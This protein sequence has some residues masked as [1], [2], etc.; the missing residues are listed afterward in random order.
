MNWD[1]EDYEPPTIDENVKAAWD[2]EDAEE[3]SKEEPAPQPAVA[4]VDTV[5]KKKKKELEAKIKEKEE[6]EAALLEAKKKEQEELDKLQ[7]VEKKLRMQKMVEESDFQNAR[8]IFMDGAAGNDQLGEES[9]DAMNP[10][11]EDEL[12]RFGGILTKKLLAVQEANTRLQFN[13]F[14]KEL[15]RSLSAEM[16]ADDLKEMG[17]HINVLSNE[18]LQ[19]MKGPGVKK[20]KGKKKATVKIERS[21]VM[22]AYV[23]DDFD[24]FM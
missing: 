22:D 20:T 21:Q 3:S 6:K 14:V 10:K 1:D 23:D 11:G 5:A 4:K 9:I 19:A 2:D 24:D 15:L 12:K 16:T 17:T 8:D 7:G 13:K 18:K